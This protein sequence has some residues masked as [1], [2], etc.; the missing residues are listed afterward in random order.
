MRGKQFWTQIAEP[1]QQLRRTAAV[2]QICL[3]VFLLRLG[4]VREDSNAEVISLRLDFPE[5]FRRAVL[6]RMRTEAAGD[7]PAVALV[8]GLHEPNVVGELFI[9]H[10]AVQRNQL[11]QLHLHDVARKLVDHA[12]DARARAEVHVVVCD[13]QHG[14]IEIA[15]R[16]CTGLERFDDIQPGADNIV[17]LVCK[18]QQRQNAADAP[19]IAGKILR[20]ASHNGVARVHMRVDK[21]R[22]DRLARGVNFAVCTIA[23]PDGIRVADNNNPVSGYA[24]RTVWNNPGSGTF[25]RDNITAK[26]QIIQCHIP[27]SCYWLKPR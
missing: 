5:N 3:E 9:A 25:H 4:Q 8:A 2:A 17:A 1:V 11:P 7:A 12:A 19:D 27:F 21:A 14:V 15:E 6:R 18:P 10:A 22:H 16:C 23:F 20:A 13:R 24:D 26:N